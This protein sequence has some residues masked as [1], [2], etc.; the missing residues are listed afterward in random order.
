MTDYTVV[1]PSDIETLDDGRIPW[2]PLA[3]HLG[4]TSFGA[5][6]WLAARAGD[7]VINE[8]SELDPD[9][10]EELYVVL[11]GR[12]RFEVG[13][14]SRDVAAGSFVYV[15]PGVRR[16]AVAEEDG[17]SVLSV[18]GTP[19]RAYEPKPWSV[20]RPLEP[21]YE[22]G[23]Y[24][25]LADRGPA[26]VEAYPRHGGVIYN[27]ACCESLAGRPE[28]AIEHLTRAIELSPVYRGLAREDPDLAPVRDDPRVQ[29]LLGG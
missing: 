29:V 19:G 18:G 11:S 27:V 24:D 23:R 21:L 25:E 16:T 9:A 28:A 6:L 17:T 12:A 22:A 20:W 7:R 10:D 3:A 5:N 13:E 2:R 1:A 15:R 14:D 8:H 26:L 4:I